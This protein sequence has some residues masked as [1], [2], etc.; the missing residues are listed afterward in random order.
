MLRREI[1]RL[2]VAGLASVLIFLFPVGAAN[3]EEGDDPGA[4]RVIEEI[5]VTARKREESLLEIPE[6]LAVITGESIDRGNIKALSQIGFQ[7]PNLNLS[8]RLDGFPNV[9]IRGLGSFGNTQGVGFYLDDT[10]IFSDASSRFGDLERIEVLKGPQG[11]LYG[12]SNVGGA[13]KFV[14][15][16]PNSEEASGKIKVLAG[17]QGTIDGE[18]HVNL[19][20]G[21]GGWAMR[22]FVF[23]ASDDGYLKNT[24]PPRANGM[25][26]SGSSEVGA[27]E[28]AGGRVSLAGPLS[29]RL[30]FYGSFR[31]NEYDGPN[32]TWVRE[33]DPH[34]LRHPNV[35]NNSIAGKHERDTKAGLIEL[36]L[37]LDGMDVLW[38]S[39]YTDTFS[40][41][42]TDIDIREEYLFDLLRPEDMMVTTHELRFTSTGEGAL[43]WTAGIY[44]SKFEE[45]MNAY[46][47]WFDTVANPDGTYSGNAAFLFGSEDVSGHWWGDVPDPAR[48]LMSVRTPAELR[49][50][51]KTHM[52]A[53]ASLSY[54]IDEW[55]WGL[56]LR[57][58]EWENKTVNR[59]A[60]IANDQ[61][62]TEI[63]PRLSLTRWLSE[64]AM[65]YGLIAWGY[66]PGGFNLT[67]FLDGSGLIPFGREEAVNYEVGWKG[68]WAD[69]RATASLAAFFIDYEARQIEYHLVQAD[70]TAIEAI[71]NFG[72]SE[73]YGIEADLSVKVTDELTVSLVA[74]TIEAEWIDAQ[75][76]PGDGSGIQDLSGNSPPVTPDFSWGATVDYRRPINNR[77]EFIAALQISHNGEYEGLQAWNP[78]TNPSFTLVN[79]QLGFLW[80]NM[81]LMLHVE[82]LTDEGYYND[83]QHFINGHDLVGVLGGPGAIVIGTLGQP[84]LTTLSLSYYF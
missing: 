66:E 70:G 17:E 74:G 2:P 59:D 28:E 56:G 40:S 83:V 25:R 31:Y 33:L 41:R 24:N 65:L 54:T 10:Q 69:G 57:V 45:E 49:N 26:R 39:S 81:D 62:D 13:V 12:G 64:E 18:V 4:S 34:N 7:V 63:M 8:M 21:D 79:G 60:Q 11:T 9:S 50:R 38:L 30:S 3:A 5:L 43:E 27:V 72:D 15:V 16:R 67:S 61:G 36:T 76:D 52:A 32:N 29:E 6:S 22:G 35:V 75:F 80:E 68:R 46:I 1:W 42:Y 23:G 47:W 53:F 44:H 55:E 19:P 71:T 78:V 82:N 73:Q 48:E 20:L 14:S 77:V 84:R 51:D 58:D 37:E